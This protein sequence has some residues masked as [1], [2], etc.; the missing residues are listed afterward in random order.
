MI[1]YSKLKK[2]PGCYIACN[3]ITGQYYVEFVENLGN[4]L[5]AFYKNV[6]DDKTHT[7][8]LL[9][10][11]H[12]GIDQFDITYDLD[13]KIEELVEKFN[14]ICLENVNVSR[15]D[16]VPLEPIMLSTEWYTANKFIYFGVKDTAM[17]NIKYA[18][19]LHEW[20][21]PIMKDSYVDH[22]IT[23]NYEE[24]CDWFRQR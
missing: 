4:K 14:A 21:Q 5:K 13:T 9:D 12:H 8:L 11:H 22:I 2:C 20:E 24:Y 7:A 17:N 15:Q 6:E 16:G 3:K 1:N 19:M 10:I 23:A 18:I